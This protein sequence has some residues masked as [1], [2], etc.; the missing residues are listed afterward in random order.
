MR[1]RMYEDNRFIV[2]QW[3]GETL[4]DSSFTL[5]DRVFDSQDEKFFFWCNTHRQIEC[6][7]IEAV[8]AHLAAIG[9]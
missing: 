7:C 4:D 8:R 9:D 2:M 5:V 6:H 1:V 3:E